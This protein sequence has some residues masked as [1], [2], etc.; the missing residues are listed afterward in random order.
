MAF[1]K[2]AVPL[3]GAL[4][5][6]YVSLWFYIRAGRRARLERRWDE[7]VA[8]GT[9]GMGQREEFVERGLLRHDPAVRRRLA[10]AVFGLPVVLI[11]VIIY[12]VNFR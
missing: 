9:T 2:L 8:A 7:K 1:V 4:A 6:A 3:L 11:S 12:L 10:I 5:L